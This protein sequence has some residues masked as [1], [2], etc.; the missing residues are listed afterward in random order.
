MNAHENK[1]EGGT[2]RGFYIAIL[3]GFLAGTTGFAAKHDKSHND[4][5][6]EGAKD[7]TEIA[8]EVRHQLVTL[9]Y[10][11]VF[12]DLA[13]R[14]DGATV[15]LLGAVT[16]PTLK[17]DAESSV[18]RIKG[19]ANVVNN[20]EVLPLSPMDDRIRI[21]TYRAIYGDAAL[22]DRYGYRAVPS[23]HILVKNGNVVLEGLVANAMDKNI[24]GI[25]ANGVSGVFSVANDLVIE[26]ELGK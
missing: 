17:S 1:Q 18:K 26:S 3:G 16:R 21:A 20:I 11:G 7:E 4:A 19:V 2:M 23:I 6:M 14:V 8:K 25:R 10:Y 22:A 13:F 24:A 9:P 15:T 5:F 12:D